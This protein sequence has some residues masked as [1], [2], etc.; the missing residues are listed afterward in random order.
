[1]FFVLLA[2]YT[3]FMA[4]SFTFFFIAIGSI[5]PCDYRVVFF[6]QKQQRHRRCCTGCRKSPLNFFDSLHNASYFKLPRNL[7]YCRCAAQTPAGA[8][9]LQAFDSKR[10]GSRPPRTPPAKQIVSASSRGFSTSCS[11]IRIS[12][13]N[14]VWNSRDLTMMLTPPRTNSTMAAFWSFFSS[15]RGPRRAASSMARAAAGTEIA[16]NKSTSR[17]SRPFTA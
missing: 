1:M 3:F 5:E 4:G 6:I 12:S 15:R 9:F 7:K 8:G 11:F 16:P 2:D 14:Q 13:S 10:G 17:V